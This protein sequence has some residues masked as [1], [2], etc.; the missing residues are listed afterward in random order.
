MVPL[1]FQVK[2]ELVC[3]A[4]PPVITF[5]VPFVVKVLFPPGLVGVCNTLLTVSLAFR[6][7]VAAERLTFVAVMVPLALELIVPPVIVMPL[8][9]VNAALTLNT[10]VCMLPIV[11]EAQ[12]T[13]ELNVG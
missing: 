5:A 11:S 12:V 2:L 8:V 10:T 4:T 13:A 6:V 1:P 7:M 9:T 3:T